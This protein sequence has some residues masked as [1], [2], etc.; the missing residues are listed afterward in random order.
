MGQQVAVIGLV[1]SK[2]AGELASQ[3]FKIIELYWLGLNLVFVEYSGQ[4]DLFLSF[5]LLL[6]N[7]LEFSS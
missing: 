7:V 2:S 1:V 3:W 4:H 5:E 6:N